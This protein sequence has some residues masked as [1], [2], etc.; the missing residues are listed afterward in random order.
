MHR[1]LVPSYIWKSQA[2]RKIITATTD[3]RSFLAGRQS[4]SSRTESDGVVG[5]ERGA[6]WARRRRRHRRPGTGPLRNTV[7]T[8]KSTTEKNE[9]N[10]VGLELNTRGRGSVLSVVSTSTTDRCMLTK[11]RVHMVTVNAATLLVPIL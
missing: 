4:C 10:E 9:L 7:L 6:R 8:T 5:L 1:I 11:G 2:Y 3:N